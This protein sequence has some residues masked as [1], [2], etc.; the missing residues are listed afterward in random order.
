MVF[1]RRDKRSLIQKTKDS[2]YAHKGWLRPFEYIWLRLKRRPGTPEFIAKGFAIGMLLSF[3]PFIGIH[4][5][6]A[7]AL[8]W[9][10]RAD[11]IAAAFASLII[12][13]PLSFGVIFPLT[14]RVGKAFLNLQPRLHSTQMDTFEELSKQMWPITSW[15]H[16]VKIFWELFLPMTIGGFIIGVPFAIGCY[17][18]VKKTVFVF[19]EKRKIIL[20]RV[21]KEKFDSSE[22]DIEKNNPHAE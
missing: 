7:I 22:A 5:I 3:T 20:E 12:N 9:I 1:Q 2:V 14:Y 17:Y 4:F 11:A 16:F 18:I 6:G 10:L 19:K 15:D 8:A 13:A 21:V